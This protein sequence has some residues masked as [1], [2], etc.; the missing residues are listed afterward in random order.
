MRLT[1]RQPRENQMNRFQCFLLAGF[2]LAPLAPAQSADTLHHVHGLAYSHD[3]QRLMVPSHHGLAVYS[4][5]KWTKASGPEHDYMGFAAT[6]ARIYSSGHPEAGSKL[7]NPFG[8]IRSGDGGKT[9]EKLGL[10]G[11]SDFHLLAAGW[12][13]NAVYVW[14][15]ERNSRMP[16]TGLYFTL[17]DGFTWQRAAAKGLAG[18]SRAVALHPNDAN[19]VAVATSNGIFLSRNAGESFAPLARGAEGLGVFFDLDAEHVWYST[20]DGQ[21]RLSRMALKGGAASIVVLPPMTKDA[22]G[23]IAQNPVNRTE[24][25][26]ATFGRNVYISRDSGGT[27]LQ[28]AERGR[29]K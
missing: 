17:N 9:W 27:W 11:E 24:Y 3:G 21:A 23:Y 28:I 4:K 5:G 13:T 29:G 10:E 22:V 12:N 15:T 18:E 8:L 14:N 6:R 19:V 25:A 26:I 7:P 2:V 20:H 1:V 16:A